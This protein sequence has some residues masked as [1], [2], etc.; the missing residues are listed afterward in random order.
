MES[1]MENEIWV[2]GIGL[3]LASY[4]AYTGMTLATPIRK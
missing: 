3:K 1:N 4:K 2:E